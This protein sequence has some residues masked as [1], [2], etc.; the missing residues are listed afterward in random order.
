MSQKLLPREHGTYAEILLPL[1]AVL[2][3]GDVTP[4]AA[5]LAVAAVAAFLAHEPS[6]ILL[7][8]RG[9]RIRQERRGPARAWLA[10]LVAVALGFAAQVFVS[11][12][13]LLRAAIVAPLGLVAWA[14]VFVARGEERTTLGEIV[15][16]VTLASSAIPIGIAAGLSATTSIAIACVWAI[17]SALAT[18]TVRGILL[19]AKLTTSWQPEAAIAS[20]VAVLAGAAFLSS[21]GVGPSWLPPALC[22]LALLSVG[23]GAFSPRP[24]YVRN[25][26]WAFVAANLMT[27]G[28]VVVGA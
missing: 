7:G 24:A 12:D 5:L 15:A 11:A 9:E 4:T 25:V 10:F 22:P 2:W 16:A 23:L 6:M 17:G 13:P 3:V 19:S 20:A 14:T 27:L 26:G 28:I 21:L 8:L 1:C 18:A